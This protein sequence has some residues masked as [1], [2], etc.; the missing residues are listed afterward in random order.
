MRLRRLVTVAAL[1]A[2][3]ACSGVERP[4]STTIDACRMQTERPHWFKAMRKTEARWGVPVSVQLATISRESSFVG[5]ARPTTK[6]KGLFFT[7]E[8]Q[9]SS[10]YGY[11]QAIDGTWDWY[12][13]DTGR[14][15]ADRDD[16]AD[17]SDFIG[18]YMNL[19]QRLNGVSTRDAY[20][21]YLAY[22][23]GKAGYAR[24]SYRNKPWLPPVAR[25]VQAWADRYEAQLQACAR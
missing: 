7:R 2:L 3:G 23:E 17:A 6:V 11:A 19:N 18:W 8:V 1:A 14:R 10:A 25:D 12:M 5:D 22:H 16:F 4:P 15:G 24:G 13:R 21:Q 9:R 20:N